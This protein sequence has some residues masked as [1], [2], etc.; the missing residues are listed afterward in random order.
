MRMGNKMKMSEKF[1]PRNKPHYARYSMRRQDMAN[2]LSFLSMH[3][4]IIQHYPLPSFIFTADELSRDRYVNPL[5]FC[6]GGVVRER[7]VLRYILAFTLTLVESGDR[8]TA[9]DDLI[10]GGCELPACFNVAWLRLCAFC[11]DDAAD[12]LMRF[13]CEGEIANAPVHEVLV[14][15]VC[16]Y[17]LCLGAAGF[18]FVG[19]DDDDVV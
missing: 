10:A 5:V 8:D 6:A 9:A 16:S 17:G 11:A 4:K 15:E 12:D 3:V 1:T 14:L 13:R 2:I 7:I 19:G 18:A